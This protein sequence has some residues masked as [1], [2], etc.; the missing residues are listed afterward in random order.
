MIKPLHFVYT[1]LNL[2]SYCSYDFSDLD[3]KSLILLLQRLWIDKEDCHIPLAIG[4]QGYDVD[5]CAFCTA[6]RVSVSY[7]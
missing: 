4:G 1:R 5:F 2:H 6:L 3:Y 7:S